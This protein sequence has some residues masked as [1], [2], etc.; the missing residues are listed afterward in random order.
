M[1][2]TAQSNSY[3]SEQLKLLHDG[4]FSK[5]CNLTIK[6]LSD[7]QRLLLAARYR[8]VEVGFLSRFSTCYVS[9]GALVPVRDY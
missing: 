3:I 7:M 4:T 9:H 2:R 5:S 1:I 6:N 8:T